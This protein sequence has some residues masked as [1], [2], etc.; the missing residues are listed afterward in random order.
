MTYDLQKPQP[1]VIRTPVADIVNAVRFE[2]LSLRLAAIESGRTRDELKDLCWR[3]AKADTFTRDGRCCVQCGAR[4]DDAHHRLPRA[5]GGTSLPLVAFG[6]ANL[7]SLCRR[8]HDYTETTGRETGWA[9][10]KG[11]ILRHGQEP[12]AVPLLTFQHGWILLGNRGEITPTTPPTDDS[13]RS[14]A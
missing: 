8:D 6:L 4:A 5:G 9:Y 10:D 7:V 3:A 2:G 11:Y 12:T 1:T 14:A 13:G